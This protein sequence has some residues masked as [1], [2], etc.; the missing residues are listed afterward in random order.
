MERAQEKIMEILN[1]CLTPE[2]LM[3]FLSVSE[4]TA[5]GGLVG[6]VEVTTTDGKTFV[7]N[8]VSTLSMFCFGGEL[9]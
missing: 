4:M 2:A 3:L 8:W 6:D 5:I 9:S 7:W 1:Q